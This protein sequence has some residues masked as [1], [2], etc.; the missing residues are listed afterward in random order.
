MTELLPAARARLTLDTTLDAEQLQIARWRAMSSVDKA[1]L[2]AAAATSVRQL[3]LAGIRGRHPAETERERL[4]RYAVI[5][6]GSPLAYRA[7]PEAEAL[8]G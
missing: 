7:Y 4:L 5:T 6:L 3:S 2:V 1:K 8:G